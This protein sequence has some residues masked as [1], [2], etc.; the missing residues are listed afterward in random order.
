MATAENHNTPRAVH[1]PGG[2]AFSLRAQ[3]LGAFLPGVPYLHNGAELAEPVPVN[4]GFDF[5]DAETAALP[6]AALPLFSA[7][8]MDWTRP[9]PESLVED[10]RRLHAL[11]ARYH[12]LATH[13][14]PGTLEILS[15]A[16][17]AVSGY[18]RRLPGASAGLAILGNADM[19]TPQPFSPPA[20]CADT[21]L[22]TNRPL[23]P[24]LAPGQVVVCPI[25]RPSLP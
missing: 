20:G 8:A 11:R 21:D 18:L 16:N 12:D 14:A 13:P 25:D 9:D 10:L 2:R 24:T 22:L 4:T 5:T 17:P 1:W 3:T 15:T 19:L 7:A 6:P 23:P